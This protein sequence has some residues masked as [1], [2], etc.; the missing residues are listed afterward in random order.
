MNFFLDKEYITEEV[1]HREWGMFDH[2]PRNELT[3]EQLIKI[4]KG[5]ARCSMTSSRD[6]PEFTKLRNQLEELGYIETQRNWYNGDRVLKDF[7]LNG[8][9]FKKN[10]TFP[11]A[12]AMK[13]AMEYATK[14]GHKTIL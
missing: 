14:M 9:K 1:I 5:E 11:C 10:A 13:V 6:H 3:H 12:I 7:T 8:K 4:I 2:I